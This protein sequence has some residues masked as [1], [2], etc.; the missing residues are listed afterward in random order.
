MK[1]KGVWSK[2]LTQ[3]CSVVRPLRWT[4]GFGQSRR[5]FETKIPPL[6]NLKS[7]PF[8][9]QRKSHFIL[10]DNLR[11]FF[12]APLFPSLPIFSGWSSCPL[13]LVHQ[14]GLSTDLLVGS[15]L[16]G[17]D[18]YFFNTPSIF[19]G[20]SPWS[21][22]IFYRSV[23]K[24]GWGGGEAVGSSIKRPPPLAATKFQLTSGGKGGI[25]LNFL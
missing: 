1:L 3:R 16:L 23:D 13:P 5:Q 11:N 10:K 19:F 4:E 14:T 17:G 15:G 20:L 24:G 25:W 7:P 18:V 8:F 9:L 12:Q 6:F 22:A 21:E 2:P